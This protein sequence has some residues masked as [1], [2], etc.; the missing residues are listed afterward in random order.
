M[1]GSVDMRNLPIQ[2][3]SITGPP[4]SGPIAG[5]SSVQTQSLANESSMAPTATSS[6]N[7][8]P[9]MLHHTRH[10]SLAS[11]IQQPQGRTGPAALASP[12]FQQHTG[13]ADALQQQGPGH[14]ANGSGQSGG[15]AQHISIQPMLFQTEAFKRLPPQT[16]ATLFQMHA[17]QAQVGNGI[18]SGFHGNPTNTGAFSMAPQAQAQAQPQAGPSSSIPISSFRGLPGA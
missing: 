18:E 16:Q 1:N 3:H 10:P 9:A 4:M 7:S 2:R 11:P 14:L 8:S 17:S 5:H 12:I 13:S 15:I 6:S